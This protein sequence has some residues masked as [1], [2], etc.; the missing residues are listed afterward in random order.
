MKAKG[1]MERKKPG[2]FLLVRVVIHGGKAGTGNDGEMDEGR[3]DLS[4]QH[5][6]PWPP[7]VLANM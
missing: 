4:L 6:F 7:S 5:T 2:L 1:K 3:G